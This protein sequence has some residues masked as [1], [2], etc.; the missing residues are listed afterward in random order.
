MVVTQSLRC[1]MVNL[2]RVHGASSVCY[3]YLWRQRYLAVLNWINRIPRL[4][5]IFL[6]SFLSQGLY[7]AS[8]LSKCTLADL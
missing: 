1:F 3:K 5:Q 8:I 4:F 7:S 6:S 2:S